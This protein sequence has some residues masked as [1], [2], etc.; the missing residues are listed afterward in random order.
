MQQPLVRYSTQHGI[1]LLE[2]DN[3]PANTY[4]YEMMTEL[5]QAILRARFDDEIYVLLLRGVGD[6]FFSAGADI[7][8]LNRVS[9]QFKYNFCLHANETLNRLE[10]TPKLVIA[11]LNGHAVGGG[12]EIAMACDLRLARRDA[13]QIGLPEI[14]LGVLPGTGGSQRLTRHVGKAR[15]LELMATGRRI[16]FE[17]AQDLG[18]VHEI[19]DAQDYFEQV[20]AYARQFTPPNKASK[21]VGRIKLAV[22]AGGEMP[23]F[24]ALSLEQELQAGLFSSADGQEGLRSYMTKSMPQFKGA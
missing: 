2:F 1:A 5:D 15:A 18:L 10:R 11:A 21:A 8:M 17:E 20:L 16:S 6:K 12:L 13:G 7:E 14:A 24:E 9:P 22:Q 3:P 4:S 19:F 23:L